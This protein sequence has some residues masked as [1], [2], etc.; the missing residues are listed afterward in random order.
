MSKKMAFLPSKLSGTG[1]APLPRLT[2]PW[3][4]RFRARTSASRSRASPRPS[5][6]PSR[7]FSYTPPLSPPSPPFPSPTP[8]PCPPPRASPSALLRR[9]PEPRLGDLQLHRLDLDIMDVGCGAGW[10]VPSLRD[11]GK[12]TATDVADDVLQRVQARNPGVRCVAGDFMEIDFGRATFDVVVCLEVLSHVADQTAFLE[13]VAGHLRPG[14]VL[15][16]ATQN[17][18]VME[19]YNRIKPPKPGNLRKW[20]DADELREL[21]SAWFAVRAL[22][23]VTPMSNRGLMRIVHSN[24]VN[25]PIRWVFGNRIDR[26]KERMGLGWTL[27]AL[28]QK[29][30]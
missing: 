5:G 2:R 21:L 30:M 8:R 6:A 23:S 9:V 19:K 25:T 16:I 11:F 27:M 17:R 14:G 7:F 29:P 1:A 3:T 4:G 22:F 10:M 13:K 18:T 24:L 20:Y 28:A 12:V 15:M 26:L